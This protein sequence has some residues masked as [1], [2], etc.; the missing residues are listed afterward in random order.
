M[1]ILIKSCSQPPNQSLMPQT[2]LDTVKPLEMVYIDILSTTNKQGAF[3]PKDLLYSA[4]KYVWPS[5]LTPCSPRGHLKRQHPQYTLFFRRDKA[6]AKASCIYTSV[7]ISQRGGGT[8]TRQ[9]N[10]IHW[11]AIDRCIGR[12]P[13]VDIKYPAYGVVLSIKIHSVSFE[14]RPDLRNLIALLH[15]SIVVKTQHSHAP[16][17]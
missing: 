10:N 5:V 15:Y 17:S 3:S 1:G 6:R 13:F 2:A 8:Q 9:G 11:D 4:V 12:E 14:A 7:F 16:T